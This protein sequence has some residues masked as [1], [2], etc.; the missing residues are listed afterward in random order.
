MLI[1]NLRKHHLKFQESTASC[2]DMVIQKTYSKFS[3]SKFHHDIV[4]T[5]MKLKFDS[6]LIWFSAFIWLPKFDLSLSDKQ[7]LLLTKSAAELMCTTDV[8]MDTLPG[9]FKYERPNVVIT[10]DDP[11]K[12]KD[13]LKL[14]LSVVG[15]KAFTFELVEKTP[16]FVKLCTPF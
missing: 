16:S 5:S 8:E 12:F 13:F 2:M 15:R 1:I 6:N 10:L 3:V 7:W 14:S 4:Y 9:T 11:D